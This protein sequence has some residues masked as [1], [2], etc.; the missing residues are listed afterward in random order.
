MESYS[1]TDVEVKWQSRWDEFGTNLF[2]GEDLA[3]VVNPYLNLMMFPNPS[4]ERL[5]VGNIYAYPGTDV[6]GRNQRFK[7]HDVFQSM[8]FD[9]FGIHLPAGCFLPARRQCCIIAGAIFGS[10]V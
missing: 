8:G 3:S 1:A 10:L 6:R 4:A 5:H 7:G 2:S 9:A